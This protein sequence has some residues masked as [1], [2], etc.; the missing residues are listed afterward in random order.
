MPWFSVN[1]V[2]LASLLLLASCGS[3]ETESKQSS[4]ARRD[5]LV[6]AWSTA[7]YGPYPLGPLT[8]ETP[9]GS[10]PGSVNTARFENNQAKNQS[11]RMI[12]NPTISG[13]RAR[14]RLSNLKGDRPIRFES[15]SLAR[16]L[17]QS[18]ILNGAQVNLTFAG[19]PFVIAQPGE[20]VI[21]DAVAFELNAQ[22][23]LAVSFFIPGESGPMTWHAVSFA[24]QYISA[25][26]SGDVTG[27]TTGRTFLDLSLGW[28]FL[29]GL[30]V[31]NSKSSGAIVAIGDSITDGAYQVL[32]QRWTDW[33]A[34][35]LN[36]SGKHIGILNQGINS[37]TVTEPPTEEPSRA[38]PAVLRFQR[39]VLQR[40]GVRG[41]IIFEGTNDLGIGLKAEPVIAGLQ[42]MA[43]RAKNAGLCVFMATIAPRMDVAF[44]WFPDGPTVKEPERVKINEW[45]RQHADVDGV[46]D[47]AEV[48][49]LPGLPNVPNPVLFTPDLLHPN[50][51]GFK[52][53]ADAIDIE[54]LVS[55]CGL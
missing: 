44:G 48:L 31:E 39:D 37:N 34:K 52:Q 2:A 43:K 27:D 45:I 15:V 46:I 19:K 21:S 54:A 41:V 5:S 6:G 11:F 49:A 24:P 55:Q 4:E 30:D 53:M 10:T 23:D 33:L 40:A 29:S 22:E 17:P 26:N 51:L 18:P 7:P 13:S 3:S 32:N 1:A 38:S 50:A 42:D 28:F 8:R 35:R 20:E 36:A 12:I 25:P 47:F 9:V 14:I 16:V